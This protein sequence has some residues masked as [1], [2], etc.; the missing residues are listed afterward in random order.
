MGY[1]LVTG[2]PPFEAGNPVETLIRVR[3]GH[4]TPARDLE[5]TVDRDLEAILVR[6][7]SKDPEARY[8]SAQELADDLDRFIAGHPVLARP[9]PRWNRILRWSHRHPVISL[10]LGGILLLV[11][12]VGLTTRDLRQAIDDRDHEKAA[13]FVAESKAERLSMEL[14]TRGNLSLPPARTAEELERLMA[15]V[16]AQSARWTVKMPGTARER[17]HP[18][19]QIRMSSDFRTAFTVDTEGR[20]EAVDIT[21]DEIRWVWSPP[22][23]EQVSDLSSPNKRH[24]LITTDHHLILLDS[25]VNPP[26][27]QWRRRDTRLLTPGEEGDWILV[28]GPGGQVRR[29]DCDTGKDL[30]TLALQGLAPGEIAASPDP[31]SPMLAVLAGDLLRIFDQDQNHSIGSWRLPGPFQTVQWSGDWIAA[32]GEQG[33]VVVHHFPSGTQGLLAAHQAAIHRLLFVPGTEYIFITTTDGQTSFWDA[34]TRVQLSLS[35]SFLP[36]Q[37]HRRGR[38]FLYATPQF[39]GLGILKSSSSRIAL[40]LVDGG[41][42]PIRSLDF[43]DDGRWLVVGKQAGVHLVDLTHRHPPTL[44]PL[45]GTLFAHLIPE[46]K[47]VLV[48]SREGFAWFPVD[49]GAGRIQPEAVHGHPH[50][51]GHLIAPARRMPG[52][53]VLTFLVQD[54]LPQALDPRTRSFVGVAPDAAP[55]WDPGVG[56]DTG[57]AGGPVVSLVSPNHH[58]GILSDFLEHRLVTWPQGNR[59]RSDAVRGSLAL[60]VPLSTWTADSRHLAWVTDRDTIA[61]IRSHDGATLT[62]LTT[63]EPSTYT[64]LRFSPDRRWLATGNSRGKVE[65]WDLMRLEAEL[66]AAGYA[67]EGPTLGPT[68]HPLPPGLCRNRMST[69]PSPISLSGSLGRNRSR[70]ARAGA[71]ILD[72]GPFLNS[73]LEEGFLS[74]NSTRPN[75]HGLPQGL[76]R[77]DDIAFDLRGM[78]RFKGG[79]VGLDRPPYP[80]AITNGFHS[81]TVHRVHLLSAAHHVPMSVKSGLEI[82]SLHLGFED[83]TELAFPIRLGEEL[84]DVWSPIGS[85]KSPKRAT[86][87]WKGLDAASEI[88]DAWLQL[89]HAVFTNAHPSRPVRSVVIRSNQAITSPIVVGVTLE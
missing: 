46:T 3:K 47:E 36:L 84:D 69:S 73:P 28:T 12:S 61:V 26:A 67:I 56:T 70:D 77:F 33:Q 13:T 60:P 66:T 58:F 89:Y 20:V 35:R 38:Q 81:R 30:G 44:H 22:D 50:T 65:L 71:D 43:S 52:E 37:I 17:S 32:G 51:T 14:E 87:A 5:P 11:T 34:A 53:S 63:P 40:S 78:I 49:L 85:P 54:G 2:E 72:L 21:R 75:L 31:S 8:R 42:P 74:P 23:G 15:E 64:A 55:S 25:T 6:C 45:P 59:I 76:V 80:T 86:V 68:A 41:L 39:W 16:I 1:E 27:E 7:L 24:L 29:V 9:I 48:Q 79:R 4:P 19:A 88:H 62:R 82:G 83:G 57:R 18:D 10:L